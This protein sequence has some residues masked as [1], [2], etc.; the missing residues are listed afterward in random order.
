MDNYSVFG[1]T[2]LQTEILYE[3]ERRLVQN[4]ISVSEK[5][6]DKK[7]MWLSE[8]NESIERYFNETLNIKNIKVFNKCSDAELL[9]YIK[10][11]SDNTVWKYMVLFE[12]VLFHAYYPFK[13]EDLKKW[14]GLKMSSKP[15]LELLEVLAKEYLQVDV[16]YIDTF[17]KAYVKSI[18]RMSNFWL[19]VAGVAG[20]V[21]V[22]VLI[23]IL[24]GQ[25]EILAWFAKEGTSGAALTS[26]GL[27]ALGGGSIAAGGGGVA[28]G[29]AVY[30][31]GGVLLGTAVGVPSGLLIATA[32]N[33]KLFLSQ[34]AKM[35]VVLKEIVLAIQKDTA[36]FQKVM[37]S[38]YE[39]AATLTAEVQKLKL[40]EENN[41]KKIKE[42]KRSISYL[43]KVIGSIQK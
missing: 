18:R 21:I 6:A 20:V 37:L 25:Y 4:D 35:E 5:N 10:S 11:D 9:K 43:E 29:T 3:L 26:S 38:L 32:T 24:T 17:K 14:K 31:G 22:L 2:A 13:K 7:K 40:E 8:W 33:S 28:L 39:Q 41:K 12:C 42:L 15:R 36:Y 23:A 1:L 27:A 34:A 19:K 30:V 16:K